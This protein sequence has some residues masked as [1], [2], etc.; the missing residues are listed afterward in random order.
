[1]RGSDA[2]DVTQ[3][4]TGRQQI[5]DLGQMQEA[6]GVLDGDQAVNDFD[7]CVCGT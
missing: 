4:L 6:D 3:G 2:Q 5:A 1:M 7:C